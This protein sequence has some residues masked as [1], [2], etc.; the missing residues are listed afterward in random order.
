MRPASPTRRCICTQTS[1][2]RVGCSDSPL[3]PADGRLVNDVLRSSGMKY[4]IYYTSGYWENLQ[5]FDMLKPQ[6]DGSVTVNLMCPD[7]TYQ[8]FTSVALVGPFVKQIFDHQDD[9]LGASIGPVRPGG[10]TRQEKRS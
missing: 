7:E 10:L 9:Y 6:D 4:T 8:M 2:V 5:F 1:T 3:Y